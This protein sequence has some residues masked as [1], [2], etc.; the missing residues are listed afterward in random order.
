MTMVFTREGPRGQRDGAD[1]AS[2]HRARPVLAATAKRAAHVHRGARDVQRRTR[3]CAF[4]LASGVAIIND[5]HERHDS[6]LPFQ[7]I[8]GARARARW[9]VDLRSMRRRRYTAPAFCSGGPSR[10][11]ASLTTWEFF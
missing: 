9:T 7:T 4:A 2:Q 10:F 8:F 11:L 6:T 3:S 1:T 5:R